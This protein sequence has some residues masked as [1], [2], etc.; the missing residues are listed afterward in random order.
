RR[1]LPEAGNRRSM[2]DERN[3]P[4]LSPRVL[5][6]V[7][8]AGQSRRTPVS[9]EKWTV[10]FIITRQKAGEQA[11]TQQFEIEVDPDEYVLDGIE[12]VWAFHDRSLLFRHACHH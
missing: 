12:R 8:T 1:G 7:G 5:P 3:A 10:K 4:A 9:Q 11:R 6:F 2:R